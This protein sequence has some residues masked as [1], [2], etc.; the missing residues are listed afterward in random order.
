MTIPDTR[1]SHYFES[2]LAEHAAL[3]RSALESLLQEQI[4]LPYLG[5]LMAEYP[6]RG[7]RMMVPAVFL[8][9]V[10][11]CGGRF[12][13]ALEV[14]AGLELLH[15]ALL[16]HRDI[17][18]DRL[19]RRGRE[20]LHHQYGIPLAINAGD[21]LTFLSLKPFLARRRLPLRVAFRLLCEM[22]QMAQQAARGW[23]TELSWRRGGVL[24]PGERAYYDM[25]LAR[26]G[27]VSS[28]GPLRL[29]AAFSS[30][31]IDL[32]LFFRFGYFCGVAFHIYEE[33]RSLT[34]GGEVG[35]NVGLRSE[36]RSLPLLI[37]LR[38][39]AAKELRRLRDMLGSPRGEGPRLDPVW[40]RSRM[41]AHGCFEAALLRAHA[42]MGAAQHETGELLASLPARGEKRLL[43]ELVAWLQERL[44]L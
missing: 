1:S 24:D 30:P 15:T 36:Q 11:V 33:V 26:T 27:W 40:I 20:T 8:T 31:R 19:S 39:A 13:D 12:E 23:L 25:A 9:G 42:L 14:A 10:R 41:E 35:S 43:T 4:D 32:D 44:Y 3:T 38:R 37:L 2:V 6:S 34:G 16:V 22:E 18:E 17:A 5:P 29:A 7:G 28:I 21:S